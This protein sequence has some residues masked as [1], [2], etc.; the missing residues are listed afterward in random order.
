MATA[1]TAL[2]LRRWNNLVA[3][4]RILAVR[5]PGICNQHVGLGDIAELCRR[6][7]LARPGR[8]WAVVRDQILRIGCDWELDQDRLD[9]KSDA[10]LDHLAL[11]LKG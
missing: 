5:M 8:D 1:R 9:Q 11:F 2:E 7:V 3:I 6:Q 4:R 10:C